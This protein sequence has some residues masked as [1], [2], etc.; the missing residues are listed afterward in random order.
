MPGRQGYARSPLVGADGV[1]GGADAARNRGA[2][3]GAR[4]PSF[5]GT[6]AAGLTTTLLPSPFGGEG[7]ETRTMATWTLASKDLRLLLRDRRAALLLLALP[8]LFILVLGLLLGE[9]FGQKADD[10]QRVSVVDLD[11]G[12]PSDPHAGIR[13]AASWLALTPTSGVLAGLTLAET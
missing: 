6:G 7:G 11:A 8:L 12:L 5:D 10:R 13:E 1:A 3:F 2:E 4:I 9:N